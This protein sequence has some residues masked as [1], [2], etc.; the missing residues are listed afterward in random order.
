[1]EAGLKNVDGGVQ[2]EHR[3]KKT[4]RVAEMSL[5]AELNDLNAAFQ[6][7]LLLVTEHTEQRLL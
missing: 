1:M 7:L 4:S 6:K 5:Q 3:V 2:R